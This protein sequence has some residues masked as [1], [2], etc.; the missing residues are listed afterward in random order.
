M[1]NLLTRKLEAFA[2]LSVDD[3]GLLDD[4]VK[5]TRT[6]AART[7]IIHEGQASKDVRLVLEGFACRYKVLKNGKRQ[8]VAYLIPGDFCDLNVFILKAMDHSI[9]TAVAV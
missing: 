3:R 9:G 7:D 2:P 4:I 8:I 5:P 1:G 6:V